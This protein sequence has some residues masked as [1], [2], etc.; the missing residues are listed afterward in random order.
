MDNTIG[1]MMVVRNEVNRIKQF[2]DY[3]L[4]FVDAVCI[5]D[6]QSDDGTWEILQKY[7][8]TSKIPFDIWQDEKHG[9]SE[10]S[11]QATADRLNTDWLLYLD[12]DEMVEINFLN[13]AHSLVLDENIDGYWLIRRN[14]FIVRVFGENTP[15][16][17]KVLEVTHPAVDRQLRLTRKKYSMFPTQIHVRVRVRRAPN[18][19]GKQRTKYLENI[20]EH[21]KTIKEQF[22]DDTRY[23]IPLKIVNEQIAKGTAKNW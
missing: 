13:T 16:E 10:P 9:I 5:A 14:I 18:E 4:P 20:I 12:P 17:P 1:L 6:Q 3:T 19:D 2:L 21:K 11:K 22:D 23:S 15:I 8:N 7:Q